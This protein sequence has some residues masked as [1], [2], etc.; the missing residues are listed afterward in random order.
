MSVNIATPRA[1]RSDRRWFGERIEALLPELYGAALRLCR[2]RTN[3]EDLVAEAVAK[4]WGALP[5]LKDRS[6]FRA[7]V[8][9][10]L[11]NTFVS[12]CRSAEAQIEKE[13]LDTAEPEPF[14]LFERLHQPILL[15][16]GNPERQFLNRLLREDI[17]RAVDALP[18]VFGEVVVMVDVEGLRYAEVADVLS[19]PVGT[20][21]SRLSRGR[22]LLQA[23][24]WEHATEAGLREGPPPS[25]GNENDHDD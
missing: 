19:I 16:W 4:A 23:A 22:S 3:A 24:L 5:S 9:R 10:I 13:P 12:R 1:T 25:T 6:S 2:H 14:S 8:F 11:N 15:W 21:R 7:W 20:V 18:P 17:E